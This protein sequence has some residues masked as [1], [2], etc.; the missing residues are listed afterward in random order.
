MGKALYNNTFLFGLENKHKKGAWEANFGV[1]LSNLL[2]EKN[3][4]N[5]GDALAQHQRDTAPTAPAPAIPRDRILLDRQ[6]KEIVDALTEHRQVFIC[7]GLFF[8]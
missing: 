2:G 5:L 1:L 6:L 8:L 4:Q 3:V 7:V